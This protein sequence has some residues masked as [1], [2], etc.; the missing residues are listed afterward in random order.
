MH[1]MYDYME[2]TS[3]RKCSQPCSST[4]LNETNRHSPKITFQSHI[5]HTVDHTWGTIFTRRPNSLTFIVCILFCIYSFLVNWD[6][7]TQKLTIIKQN[8]QYCIKIRSILQ[9]VS[10]T[11]FDP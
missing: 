6:H 9:L 7:S 5:F 3:C 8:I 1:V 4:S 10:A 11:C 2:L